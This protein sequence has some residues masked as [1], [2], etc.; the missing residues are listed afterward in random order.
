ML[1]ISRRIGDKIYIGRDIVITILDI[2]RYGEFRFGI[3]A[4][5]DVEI[6]RGELLSE[7]DPRRIKSDRETERFR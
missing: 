7:N 5:K 6:M 2:S 3:S 4:P 1:C